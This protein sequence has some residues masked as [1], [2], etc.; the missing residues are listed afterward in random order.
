MLL[1]IMS[2]KNKSHF[3]VMWRINFVKISQGI[4]LG[5]VVISI[6]INSQ[7]YKVNVT[8]LWW[9]FSA[10]A[11]WLLFFR[12][13]CL[14]VCFWPSIRTLWLHWETVQ[15]KETRV[16]PRRLHNRWCDCLNVKHIRRGEK[17]ERKVKTWGTWLD[18]RVKAASQFFTVFFF[19]QGFG[20]SA[21]V[22]L[23]LLE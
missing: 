18:V 8:F 20:G 10:G 14:F 13:V 21:T 23:R 3:G 12:F 5:N 11:C 9:G 1:H 15:L 4:P 6:V 19:F 17:R 7:D 16:L 22:S 2:R